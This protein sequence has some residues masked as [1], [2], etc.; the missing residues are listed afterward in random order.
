[1]EKRFDDKHVIVTGASAGIGKAIAQRFANEGAEVLLL[2]RRKAALEETARVMNEKTW[3]IATVSKIEECER[4]VEAAIRRWGRID[5]LVNNAG[6]D[7]AGFR[8]QI[9]NPQSPQ[10]S[11][12]RTRTGLE[13][14]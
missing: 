7:N 8:N 14:T 4:A 1:L 10:R 3:Y 6:I 12:L 5:V 11:L 9:A 13:V 2:S